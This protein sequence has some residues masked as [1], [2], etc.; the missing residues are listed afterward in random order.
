MSTPAENL[1]PIPPH[2]ADRRRP[3]SEAQ[4]A[5]WP[6]RLVLVIWET[7][8]GWFGAHAVWDGAWHADTAL[9][10]G[11]VLPQQPSHFVEAWT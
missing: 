11:R 10:R 1:R 8:A 5:T 3:I 4:L 9:H 6:P 2:I 7:P